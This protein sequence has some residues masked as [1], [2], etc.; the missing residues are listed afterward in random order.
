MAVTPRETLKQ[1]FRKYALP[2]EAQFWELIDAFVHKDEDMLTQEKIDGL[3]AALKGKASTADLDSFE[4]EIRA[5]VEG[6]GGGSS[7]LNERL[8]AV[9]ETLDTKVDTTDYAAFKERIESFLEDADASDETINKWKEVE[10]FLDGITDT[11][12]LAGMLADLKAEIVALIPQQEQGNFVK[13]VADLDGYSEAQDGEI[14]QYVGQTSENYTRGFFYE[15]KKGKRKGILKIKEE[16]AASGFRIIW[17][18]GEPAITDLSTETVG[19][20]KN[21]M[22][23][24]DAAGNY[25]GRASIWLQDDGTILLPPSIE[26]ANGNFSSSYDWNDKI[27]WALEDQPASWQVIPTGPCV[28]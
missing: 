20:Y 18:T 24:T 1:Y 11:K 25:I 21:V 19:T 16:W 23:F 9:E 17:L 15:R 3:V 14:V 13:Q 12:T 27:D 10:N 7:D 28:G 6:A 4:A 26:D 2:T 5:A 8:T 22:T